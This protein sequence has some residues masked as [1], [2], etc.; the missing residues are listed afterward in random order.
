MKKGLRWVSGA[1]VICAVIY[2]F[3]IQLSG[4]GADLVRF[5]QRIRLL[6]LLL[7]I[8]IL[9]LYH[10]ILAFFFKLWLKLTGEAISW[11]RSFRILYISQMARFLPGGIWGYVGRVYLGEG[12][13]LPKKKIILASAAQLFLNLLTG[14]ILAAIFFVWNGGFPGLRGEI[15]F[16]LLLGA[17]LLFGGLFGGLWLL[18][19]ILLKKKRREGGLFRIPFASFFKMFFFY[20]GHWFLYGAAFWFF[21]VSVQMSETLPFSKVMEALSI[22]GSSVLAAPFVP[23]GIG[24]REGLLAFVLNPPLLA[25]DAALLALFSRIWLILVDLI[26]FGLA[27]SLNPIEAFFK[28]R[29]HP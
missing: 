7:S 8:Q 1:L 13:G 15:V 23:G 19:Q 9:I 24:V 20:L 10:F 21:I 3:S 4:E 12:D 26:C 25:K 29:I 11:A 27:F 14:G 17:A 16:S 18:N 5:Y 2:Y 28:K 22:S 6:P